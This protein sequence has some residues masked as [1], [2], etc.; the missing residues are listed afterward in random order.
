[1]IKYKMW[2]KSKYEKKKRKKGEKRK[3][4]RKR[5]ICDRRRGK[6]EEKYEGWRGNGE[7]PGA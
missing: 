5:R 3:C 4:V 1:M 6:W 2:R 7:R